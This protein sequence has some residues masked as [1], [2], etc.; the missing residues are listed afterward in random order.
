MLLERQQLPTLRNYLRPNKVILLLGPRRVGKTV[1]ISQLV[2]ELEEPYVLLNG[3]SANTVRLLERRTVENYLSLLDGS[4]VLVIDEAQKVPDIGRV[5]KLMIDEIDGLRILATGSSAYDIENRM[6]EP[7]TGRKYTFRLFS[8]SEHEL[9]QVDS[10]LNAEDHLRHRLVFGNYPELLQLPSDDERQFYLQELVSTYLL[11]DI[12][13]FEGIRNSDKILALLRL[14]AFQVGAEVSY[15]ELGRQLGMDKN[16]VERYLDLLSKVFIIHQVGGFSRNLRKEIVKNKRWYFY[17]NGIRNTLTGNFNAIAIRQDVGALWE[18]YAIS[19][20]LK[21]QSYHRM[22]S[23]NY[24]WRTYDQQEI[25]WVEDRSGQLH[26]YEFKWSPTK[27]AK[28]PVAW[29]KAYPNASFEVI[30][31]DNLADWIKKWG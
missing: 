25:D 15:S 11:K 3:E 2:S 10:R 17:D 13:A 20:R 27:K 5:L 24:F 9:T 23:Y 14:L 6:G 8:L 7:L 4:R 26:A 12:L 22:L 29:R 30:H 19:E 21:Y 1:L 31:R 16:T 28:E 18:N